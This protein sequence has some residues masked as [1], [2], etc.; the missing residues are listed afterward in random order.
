MPTCGRTPPPP[1]PPPAASTLFRRILL[2]AA[3]GAL[4]VPRV[5]PASAQVVDTFDDPSG[6]DARW[7]GDRG[8]WTITRDEDPGRLAPRPRSPDDTLTLAVPSRHDMGDWALTVGYRANLTHRYVLRWYLSAT[9]SRLA[10][11]VYGY[12]L[13]VGGNALDRIALYRQDGRDEQRELIGATPHGATPGD[14]GTVRLVVSRRPPGTWTLELDGRAAFSVADTTY[15]GSRFTGFWTRIQGPVADALLLDDLTVEG[16]TDFAAPQIDR[17]SYDPTE[18]VLSVR[19]D[20]PIDPSTVARGAFRI[21]PVPGLPASVRRPHRP[22]RRIEIV[23]VAPSGPI[24][25]SDRGGGLRPG[26]Y[27][28]RAPG[29]TDLSGNPPEYAHGAPFEV[30]GDTARPRVQLI[31]LL[32]TEVAART[33][34]LRVHPSEAIDSASLPHLILHCDPEAVLTGSV[35]ASDRIAG[36]PRPLS[37][38]VDART[39]PESCRLEGLT[40]LVG[41]SIVSSPRAV[42]PRARAGD[43]VVNELLAHTRSEV[44]ADRPAAPEY[45]EIWNRSDRARS[46]YGLTVTVVGPTGR[47]EELLAPHAPTTLQGRSYWVIAA[48]PDPGPDPPRTARIARAFP[49]ADLHPP[50]VHLTTV[51]RTRLGL[52]D[53]G[54]A[55]V[56]AHPVGRRVDF[57]TYAPDWHH[58]DLADPRGAA[59]ARIDPFGPSDDASN[60][61]SSPDGGTPGHPNELA[62]DSPG[63]VSPERTEAFRLRLEPAVFSPDGDGHADRLWISGEFERPV[64]VRIRIFD[65]NGRLVRE[66]V[67]AALAGTGS[68]WSWDGRDRRG[69]M[70]PVGPYVVLLE[71]LDLRSGTTAATR[72]VAVL[73]GP[74]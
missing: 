19:F 24:P 44:G 66:V 71:L 34:R 32:D 56:L 63:D 68:R 55:I 46:L 60:W 15:R 8:Q 1:D 17:A 40:D 47:T 43:L 41:R 16:P 74:P 13:Q 39:P 27:V 31:E 7:V 21:D 2:T 67:P 28:V 12:Y 57:L 25:E 4:A 36:S 9:T 42:V 45:L 48:D 10:D 59:L 22:R 5:I 53:A 49:R 14:A 58:P 52:S 38:T 37:L 65:R 73:A 61:S 18:G 70:S 50:R 23:P 11:T 26:A 51:P 35:L 29:V 20:E 62:P 3:L 54:A 72:G 30:A 64:S 6:P 33:Y 69:R